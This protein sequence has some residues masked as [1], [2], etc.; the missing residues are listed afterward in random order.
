M[1][2]HLVRVQ[3]LTFRCPMISFGSAA[4]GELDDEDAELSKLFGSA[5]L[6]HHSDNLPSCY[7][8]AMK[9]PESHKW[10]AAMS[11]EMESLRQSH[12]WELVPLPKGGKLI[13]NRWVFTTKRDRAGNVLRQKA[14]L[15]AKGFTQR[16]GIDF[17][18]EQGTHSANN[19]LACGHH[20]CC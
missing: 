18:G 15:V 6:T 9:S 10:K 13:A 11:E 3:I 20:S 17:R 4:D 7:Q 8:E 5:M 16:K 19:L 1:R 2:R 14:R 12:T